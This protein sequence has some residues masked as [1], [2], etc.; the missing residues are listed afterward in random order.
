M[1]PSPKSQVMFASAFSWIGDFFVF[2][3]FILFYA[4][5]TFYTPGTHALNT[6]VCGA[7]RL[8]GGRQNNVGVSLRERQ[9]TTQVMLGVSLRAKWGSTLVHNIIQFVLNRQWNTCWSARSCHNRV[10]MKTWKSS[11]SELDHALSTVRGSCSDSRR[12][13][14][15]PTQTHQH[16]RERA[17]ERYE[18][19][20]DEG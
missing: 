1:S 14:Y 18:N 13:L 7:L 20:C 8:F 5:A 12:S 10:P 15:T 3:G 16:L 2:L 4:T 9:G 19:V 11:T 6:C 17:T